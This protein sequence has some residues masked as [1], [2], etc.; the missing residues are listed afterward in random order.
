MK[1]LKRYVNLIPLIIYPYVYLF[2][3]LFY[4]LALSVHPS[5]GNDTFSN[6]LN[7]VIAWGTA[8]YN[9]Y[10][11]CF[12]IYHSVS[13]VRKDISAFDAAL[14]NLVVKGFHV[15]SYIFHVLI[16]LLGVCLG[17]FG[18]F[19][20]IIIAFTVTTLTLLL[21]GI[22][23]IGCGIQMKREGLLSFGK[24]FLMQIASFLCFADIGVAIAY[25]VISRKNH[26]TAT[27]RGIVNTI[28][29]AFSQNGE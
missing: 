25:V 28:K 21:T 27:G 8:I 14:M 15:P 4:I 26:S 17:I 6:T 1:I 10:L 20:F 18:G 5:A 3:I 12:C 24:V 22:S 11:L 13:I 23:S 7:N 2:V 9:I 29:Q 16:G 19:F